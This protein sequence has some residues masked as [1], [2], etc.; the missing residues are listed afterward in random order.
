MLKAMQLSFL[1]VPH[2]FSEN[3]HQKKRIKKAGELLWKTP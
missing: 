3:N 2:T 1:I